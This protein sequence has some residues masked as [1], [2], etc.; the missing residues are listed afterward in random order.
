MSKARVTHAAAATGMGKLGHQLSSRVGG[1][2][3]AGEARHSEGPALGSSRAPRTPPVPTATRKHRH[4]PDMPHP[5]PACQQAAV[6][7]APMHD[8]KMHPHSNLQPPPLIMHAARH[9]AGSQA[10][11]RPCRLHPVVCRVGGAASPA[12][13]AGSRR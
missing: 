1:R 13:R 7:Q 4:A 12:R 8:N 10:A 3:P 11:G 9:K 2:A 5:Q 6:P